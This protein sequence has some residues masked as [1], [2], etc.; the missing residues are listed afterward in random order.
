MPPEEENKQNTSQSIQEDA[1]EQN[2]NN[3]QEGKPDDFFI[4]NLRTYKN[5]IKEAVSKKDIT[6]TRILLEEQRRRSENVA[7]EEN[8]SL[9]SS[10]N[11][12]FLILSLV[13]ILIAGG[14]L[15]F[16]WFFPKNENPNIS[17]ILIER[18]NFIEVDG[19]TLISMELR[20]ARAI[21]SDIARLIVS[22]LPQDAI[23]ELLLSKSTE[24]LIN[25]EKVLVP[26]I[27]SSETFFLLLESRAPGT[28]VRSLSPEFML[29]LFGSKNI[30]PF[31]LFKIND[32]ENTYSSML[33]WE[34]VLARD[35]QP[36]FFSHIHREELSRPQVAKT[37][38]IEV[39]VSTTTPD[40]NTATST[41]LQT[42]TTEPSLN[43]DPTRLKDKVI[44]NT[45][46]RAIINDLGETVFF[47]TFINGK[48][49]FF[50]TS[51][52]VLIEVTRRLRQ[53]RLIR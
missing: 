35:M 49:L 48:Y 45:D 44:A 19:Q 43:F 40:G 10:R 9:S 52:D 28:L 24:T 5:D 3:A 29:G 20:T 32:F 21:F 8:L 46:A 42:V 38:T 11:K 15:G 34:Q 1:L 17:R 51:E 50:S 30:E 2:Q 25:G 37:E 36:I 12:T 23:E 33:N 22:N 53:A 27:I 13:F 16:I 6:S 41:S 39:T 14:I 18:P 26:N 31:L 7:N 47:Y 4:R